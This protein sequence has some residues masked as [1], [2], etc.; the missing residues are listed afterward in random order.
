MEFLRWSNCQITVEP[1]AELVFNSH[2]LYGRVFVNNTT[3][4]IEKGDCQRN[5]VDS[6]KQLFSYKICKN[7]AISHH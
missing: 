5:S 1:G 6:F 7:E 2:F 3:E 4:N